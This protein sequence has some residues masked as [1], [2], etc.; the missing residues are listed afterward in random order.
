MRSISQTT[1]TAA[2]AALPLVSA[3]T[4]AGMLAA[5]RRGVALANPSGEFAVYTN[6]NYSFQD[7][8]A[9]T[10]WEKLD[11][12]S[13]DISTWTADSNI[14]EV[15]FV[16]P[17]NT[18]ILYINGTNEEGDGGISLYT[19]DALNLASASLVASLPAPFAGLKAVATRAGDIHFLVYAQAYPNG[20]AYN[21]ELAETPAS[22]A[23]IYTDIYIRH[24]DTYLTPQRNAVFGGI[25]TRRNA[26]IS[27]YTSA[28]AG[29]SL[30]GELTNYVTGKCN[31]TCA[32]SPVQPF[33]GSGDYDISPDGTQVVYLTKNVDLP[34]ANFTSSQIYWVPFRGGVNDSI[35]INPIGAIPGAEG[36][37]AS[38][39]FSKD[40]SKIAYFQMNGI[41]YES[42]RNI[43]YVANADLANLNIT[44]VAGDWDRSPDVLVW[45]NDGNVLYVAAADLGR[46]RV[47]PVPANAAADYKPTNITDEGVPAGMQVLANNQI[48]VSDSKIWS[49]RDI[50]TVSSD[51]DVTKIYLQANL[52]DQALSG[53]GP[54][55]VSE[56]YFS[57]NSTEID[58]QSWIIYPANF[59][60]DRTY[61]L[62]FLVHGGPQSAFANSWSTRWNYKVWADQGY[63]VIA[64]NPTASLGWGQ[65]L[66]DAVSG[67]WGDYPYWDLVY[68]WDHVNSSLPY[69]DTTRGIAAGAS[70]G[71]Y[72]MNWFQGHPLGRRFNALVTHDGVTNTLA[73]YG[74]EELWFINHDQ[75]G[76]FTSPNETSTYYRWNPILY[77]ENWATPHFVVHNDLDYRLPVSEGVMLFNMLQV[78]GVPSKFLNFPDENHWVLQ[79]EN[80]L[81]WH[82]EIFKW[83][84]YYSGL[85]DAD[86][87][88]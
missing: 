40:G 43:I 58:L 20:T 2:L 80:S 42:D 33:G 87:P 59:S 64:P 78:K 27:R 72:M 25:L 23:R 84:N 8:E 12:T 36:A 31:A 61:P 45:S 11:L 56:F 71:G 44:S 70:F 1:A 28:H 51:G 37:S 69:V 63:V 19:A 38:P 79:R 22:T 67:H 57:S 68:A 54:Q 16:G 29:Y 50:Y 74:T 35:P 21:A 60:E 7:H 15:V 24:W 66:T 82:A 17:T 3:I 4:P 41:D 47:F 26:T 86:S 65:N 83:I 88:Y 34:L 46:Q 32:E 76:V 13:G 5:P 49:S 53:L 14:S 10:V 39:T 62:A 55:D 81:V 9:T 48:L 73:D 75:G 77:Y 30:T 18:S 52:F 6:T 85:S